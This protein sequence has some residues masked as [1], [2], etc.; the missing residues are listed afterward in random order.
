L[1]DE[2]GNNLETE[3]GLSVYKDHQTISIQEMP[4]KAP[5]GNYVRYFL[6]FEQLAR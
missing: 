4:E 2:D 5:A 3:Y 6:S 1:Q